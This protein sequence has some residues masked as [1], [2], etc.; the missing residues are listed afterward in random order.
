MKKNRILVTGASGFV[1]KFLI[2]KLLRNEN[3]TIVALYNN[4]IVAD[5]NSD[6][7]SDFNSQISWVKVDLF[8][9]NVSDILLDID[10]VYHLA[11]Y[12]SMGSTTKELNLLNKVNVIA[13]QRLA[14]ACKS[15]PI[16]HFIFVSSVAVCESSADLIINEKNGLP[17]TP[18]GK[19]KKKAEE[20]LIG[21]SKGHY[22]VTILRPTALFGE[23]H[24]GSVYEMVKKI[25]E[26]RFVKFGPGNSLTNFYY[27]KDFV[28]LLVHVCCNKSTYN[29]VFI[30]SDS[31]YEL[32]IVVNW[33]LHCLN[34]K[35]RIL[36]FPIWFG[37]ILATFFE[38]I[39]FLINKP[40][41]FSYRRL[42]AMTN[43]TLFSN[44]KI[45]KVVDMNCK[46]GVHKG[47]VR[48]IKWYKKTGI[49]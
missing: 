12:S 19:S 21:A 5:L 31:P 2:K 22:N 43:K 36:Q 45:S 42:H 41:L 37:Y 30:V 7:N 46:Y 16:K 32:N 15:L 13:T 29:Q 6:L 8:S 20:L 35:N 39:S 11:G 10:I 49:L 14:N 3:N 38:F 34:Y 40:L 1:G 28:N 17:L 4:S 23:Y 48:T 25:Q 33:M 24:K 26:K 18:Y 9:D 44:N 27:I 47:L